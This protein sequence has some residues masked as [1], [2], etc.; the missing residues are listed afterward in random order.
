[1]VFRGHT[2]FQT[3]STLCLVHT[4][5]LLNLNHTHTHLLVIQPAGHA[6]SVQVL[7]DAEQAF[8]AH[9]DR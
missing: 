4:H 6:I 5:S 3:F 2:H 7:S 9:T 1:M 8:T